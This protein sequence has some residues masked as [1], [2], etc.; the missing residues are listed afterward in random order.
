M[1]E[2]PSKVTVV[3]FDVFDTVLTRNVYHPHELFLRIQ[4]RLANLEKIDKTF[5]ADSFRAARVAAEVEARNRLIDREDTCLEDIMRVLA[6]RIGRT[7]AMAA[8]AQCEIE[9]E[10]RS[11]SPVASV[12]SLVKELRQAGKQIIFISD[13]YLPA[14]VI[15]EMLRRVGALAPQDKIYVSAAVGRKKSTGAMFQ[16]V[17]EDLRISPDQM[18]HFGDYLVSDFLVPRFK[19]GIC[20]VPIRLARNNIYESLWGASCR[21]L[22]CSSLAGASRAARVAMSGKGLNTEQKALYALGSNVVAPIIS[23]FVLATL[24]EAQRAGVHR[25]YFLS[26]DGEVILEIAKELAGRLD[27]DIEL[28]YLHVSRTA[29]FTALLG[30]GVDAD[31]TN[32]L[33]ESNIALTVRILADRVKVDA[34]FLFR[35]LLKAG[36]VLENI[37]TPLDQHSLESIGRL[38]IEDPVLGRCLAEVG[39]NSLRDLAGFLEGELFFDG[40]PSGLVDLGWRGSIQDVLYKCFS[41]RL[42]VNGLAGYYFGVDSAGKKDC[43]KWGYFFDYRKDHQVARYRELFRVLLELLCSGSHGMVRGYQRDSEGYCRPIFNEI[44]NLAN[45]NRI[46]FLR[47]GCKA[48][49]ANFDTSYLESAGPQHMSFRHLKHQTLGVLKKLFLFPSRDE[50]LALGGFYFSADQAGHGVHRIA[51]PFSLNSAVRYFFHRSYAGRSL[52]SSWFFASWTCTRGF[53]WFLLFSVVWLLRLHYTRKHLGTFMISRTKDFFNR[54]IDV[55]F[56]G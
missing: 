41:S 14:E 1:R 27:I 52:I 18:I 21:C 8:I 50:A 43:T 56:W 32:W 22:Y 42:G 51:P 12:V 46:H 53:T 11:V 9:E 10:V 13:M 5:S 4:A 48:F 40:T 7:E 26:R 34:D 30:T 20:S 19:K 49:V 36:L 31:T 39:E 17:L 38:L 16:Y 15:A 29:V 35:K 33:W 25:L 37:D 23:G 24:H 6:S 28:R 2:I 3:S 55:K 47:E 44:E 45:R 54:Q